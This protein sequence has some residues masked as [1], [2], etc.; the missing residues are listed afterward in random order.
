[1]HGAEGVVYGDAGYQGIAQRLGTSGKSTEFLVAIR[2]G[3]STPLPDTPDGRL[4][5][6]I[7]TFVANVR[8]KCEHLS[9]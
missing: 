8:S 9:E 7:E 6:L 2:P 4:Q 1:M 3:N 5:D